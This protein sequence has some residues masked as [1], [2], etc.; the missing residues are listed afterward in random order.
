MMKINKEV[1][2]ALVL[3]VAV[4]VLILGINFLK[5]R[6]IFSRNDIYYG[7]Y[8]HVDGLKVSSGVEYRGYN[9]GQITAIH[10]VGERYDK[11]LV[12]FS[13][14]KKLQIPVN[15][16]AVIQNIDLIGTKAINILP[17]DSEVYAQSGD[18][19]LS[20]NQLGLIDQVNSQLSPLK[21]KAETMMASLDT[22]LSSVQD[23]L[24]SNTKQDIE[25]SFKSIRNTLGNLE[26]AS[27]NLDEMVTRQVRNI[28]EILSNINSITTNLKQNNEAIST[29]LG[30]IAMITDSL[31]KANVAGVITN[32]DRVLVGI[33]T[34]MHKINSGEGTLGELVNSDELYYNL[35]ALSDNLDHLVKE[36]TANPKKFVNLSVFNFASG[37]NKED[38]YGI[39][40]YESDKPLSRDA[41]LFKNYPELEEYRVN[42]RFLY[43]IRTYKNLKQANKDIDHIKQSF[44][45]AYIVKIS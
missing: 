3:I 14:G 9:V 20:E 27:G 33:D 45:G 22:V 36:F 12:Q 5:A 41:E 4:V 24:N 34:L 43:L 13:V 38:Q 10:F 23:I 15:S 8:D 26:N 29:S 25:G 31:Y 18:T 21:N 40:I 6:T 17:G 11:V 16:V 1:K 35:A 2:L 7:I 39:A 42:G 44:A 28:E 19:L 37:K 32:L 30:N